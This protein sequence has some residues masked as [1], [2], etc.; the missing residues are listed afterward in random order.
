MLSDKTNNI[1]NNKNIIYKIIN[2]YHNL[3]LLYIIIE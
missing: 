3:N 2:V 1:L